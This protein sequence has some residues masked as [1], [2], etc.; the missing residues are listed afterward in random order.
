MSIPPLTAN[1]R[2]FLS[3]LFLTFLVKQHIRN[4]SSTVCSHHWLSDSCFPSAALCALAWWFGCSSD[5][6]THH[7]WKHQAESSATFSSPESLCPM[8]WLSSFWPNPLRPYVLCGAS[9]WARRLLCAILHCWPKPTES[10][11]FS[12]AWKMERAQWGRASL[13]HPLKWVNDAF[14]PSI[15]IS[16]KNGESNWDTE[17]LNDLNSP[18]FPLFVRYLSAWVWSLSS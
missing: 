6:T 12:M 5:I 15:C 10:P 4:I 14:C 9:A 13:A 16:Q 8:P 1:N 3:L 7:W 17:K 11:E 2:I 18:F